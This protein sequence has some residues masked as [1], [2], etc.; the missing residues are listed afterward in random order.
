MF[1]EINHVCHRKWDGSIASKGAVFLLRQLN[2]TG[3]VPL[4]RQQDAV[5]HRIQRL[6]ITNYLPNAVGRQISL[7][8]G[9]CHLIW[10]NTL[11][12]VIIKAFICPSWC[13]H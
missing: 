12:N 11:L 2:D 1:M 7:L 13:C 3:L 8:L 10:L 4:Q 5:T 6:E 9:V